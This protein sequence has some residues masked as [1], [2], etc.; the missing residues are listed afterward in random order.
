MMDTT[1]FYIGGDWVPPSTPRLLN[2]ENP[3][4]EEVVAQIS[5]GSADD[6]DRAARAARAAFP[7]FSETSTDERIALLERVVHEY[8][9][10]AD[11]LAAAVTSEMGAPAALANSLRRGSQDVVKALKCT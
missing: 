11:D 7:A 2:V 1:R 6:V 5:L 3:A 9:A 8:R 10:R 4:T